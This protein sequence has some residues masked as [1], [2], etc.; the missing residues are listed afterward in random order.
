MHHRNITTTQKGLISLKGRTWTAY[1]EIL[2]TWMLFL[3]IPLQESSHQS[4]GR[5]VGI[6]AMKIEYEFTFK[7]KFSWNV[8]RDFTI[9]RR[10][11]NENVKN[12][13][14]SSWQNNSYARASHF[15]VHFFAVFARLP[16]EIA[17]LCFL[18]RTV[19]AHFGQTNFPF[20]QQNGKTKYYLSLSYLHIL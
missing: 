10:D 11:S 8:T 12:Y 6:I 20:V 17:W 18:R 14:R 16:R 5:W 2:W 9:R 15:F 4:D 7:G 13:N 19:S 1:C 3:R